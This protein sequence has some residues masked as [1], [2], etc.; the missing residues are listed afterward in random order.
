MKGTWKGHNSRYTQALSHLTPWERIE[1]VQ[2]VATDGYLL[3][4]RR[5]F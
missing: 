5:K 1:P 3:E 4:L 2:S